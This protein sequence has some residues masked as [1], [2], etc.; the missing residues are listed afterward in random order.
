MSQLRRLLK[1]ET[2]KSLTF[3]TQHRDDGPQ[4]APARGHLTYA[5]PKILGF[6]L[7]GL[8]ISEDL[9]HFQMRFVGK[10][11]IPNER[12]LFLSSTTQ[13]MH[14]TTKK[15]VTANGLHDQSVE[16]RRRRLR[17]R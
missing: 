13:K 14:K 17:R 3:T 9:S 7:D 6:N 4:G 10:V 5:G 2:E 11:S 15:N 8:G 1:T 16:R 12:K